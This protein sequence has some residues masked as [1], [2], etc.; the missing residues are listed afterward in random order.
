MID[1]EVELD[2]FDEI[3]R[4]RRREIPSTSQTQGFSTMHDSRRYS[5][6]TYGSPNHISTGLRNIL[7]KI[8]INKLLDIFRI[9]RY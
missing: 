8:L 6:D 4:R 9:K 2:S 5:D 1:L 3:K 7:I